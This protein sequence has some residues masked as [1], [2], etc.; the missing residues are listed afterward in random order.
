[1]ALERFRGQAVSVISPDNPEG[2]EYAL[3]FIEVFKGAGWIVTPSGISTDLFTIGYDVDPIGIQIGLP[4]EHGEYG[5]D[6]EASKYL[7]DVLRSHSISSSI[8]STTPLI[9]SAN[10]AIDFSVGVKATQ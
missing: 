7:Y 8:T 10:G 4:K 1:M 9:D 5:E 2:K 6:Y 3:D